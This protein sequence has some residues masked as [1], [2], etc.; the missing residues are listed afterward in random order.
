MAA[1]SRIRPSLGEEEALWASGRRHVAGVDEVGR[2][3]LAGPLVAAA[4]ILDPEHLPDWVGEVADSK[5][6]TARQREA[7]AVRIEREALAV[8][9]G[10]VSAHEIDR[11][12]LTRANSAAMRR[13]VGRLA[14]KADFVLVDGNLR[15]RRVRRPLQRTIVDGDALCVSISAASIVAKVARD[16]LMT[17][18]DRRYPGYGF[19]RHK[20]YATRQHLAQLSSL[21][22]CAEH[23]RCFLPVRIAGEGRQAL[24]FDAKLS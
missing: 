16:R 19:A 2:G 10:S 8:A 5:L 6:L 20:G 9:I 11:L 22:P 3:P 1:G 18:L 17:R 4:V 14:V 15:I 24:L 13:A 23:R 7:L 12:G 21:G